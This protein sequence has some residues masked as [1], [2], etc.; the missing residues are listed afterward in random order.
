MRIALVAPL[1][2]P[3]APPFIGGAQ[4]LLHDL[5]VTLAQRGHTVTLFAARGSRAEQVTVRDLDIEATAAQQAR[6]HTGESPPPDSSFYRQGTDFW[7]VFATLRREAACYDIVHVHAFDWPAYA[8]G[9]L[10]PLPVLH[11]LHLPAIAPH[12]GSLL[13]AIR[14]EATTTRLVTVSRACAA[15]WELYTP[16]D[17]VIYNGIRVEDVPFQAAAADYL[18]FAGRIAPEKGVHH[19]IEIARHARLPL[20]IA[21]DIYDPA[22]FARHVQPLLEDARGTVQYLGH[23]SRRDLYRQMGAARALLCPIGW[24]EP[25]GLVAVE[26][27]AAG[28]PVIAFAR[29]AMPEIVQDGTTGLLV[30]PDDIPMAVAAVARVGTISRMAC[31]HHVARSFS[32][33]RMVSEY[34]AFYARMPE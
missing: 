10:L 32:L 18:F 12:I 34:E 15:T 5:A 17:A 9:A 1:V 19:A 30:A 14:A 29:G 2:T 8:F 16:V 27:M 22:Y 25:F 31:R 28:T 3:I 4:A 24:E 21:G 7:R 23:L 6:L 13:H 26:A 20:R 33:E 11:T